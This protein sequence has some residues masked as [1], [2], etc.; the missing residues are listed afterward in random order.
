[1]EKLIQKDRQI[2]FEK[3][4]GKKEHL[5]KKSNKKEN[6]KLKKKFLGAK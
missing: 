3:Q 1:V 5:N 6:T 4:L 2:T